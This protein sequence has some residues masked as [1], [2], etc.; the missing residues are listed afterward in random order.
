MGILGFGKKS[1]EER[2]RR[3]AEEAEKNRLHAEAVRKQNEQEELAK[4]RKTEEERKEREAQEAE[5]AEKKRIAEEE[6]KRN[7]E[8][9]KEKLRIAEEN[10]K[11]KEAEERQKAEEDKKQ[12]RIKKNMNG[13]ELVFRG[14]PWGIKLTDAKVLLGLPNIRQRRVKESVPSKYCIYGVDGSKVMKAQHGNFRNYGLSWELWNDYPSGTTIRVADKDTCNLELYFACVPKEG[15]LSYSDEDTMLYAATYRFDKEERSVPSSSGYSRTEKVPVETTADDLSK[16]L[17]LLYGEPDERD[18]E[19]TFIDYDGGPTCRS[20][21]THWY[22]KNNTE[23]AL[24][25]VKND[26]YDF[27]NRVS[28]SYVWHGISDV[29]LQADEASDPESKTYKRL[30]LGANGL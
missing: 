30:F 20:I 23:I 8:E 14:L 24:S 27:S 17:I 26:K 2:E 9:E 4:L 1:R 25:Q 3:E 21:V 18:A 6:R 12:R 11:L 7:E 28:I 22:G 10:R 13:E 19:V 5:A 16:K 15:K 29:L